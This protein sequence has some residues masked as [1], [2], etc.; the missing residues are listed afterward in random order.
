MNC[1]GGEL[2]SLYFSP[3][4]CVIIE[5]EYLW[6]REFQTPNT[7]LVGSLEIL[8][9]L[10]QFYHGPLSMGDINSCPHGAMKRSGQLE[11]VNL[12]RSGSQP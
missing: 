5:L 6:A 10:S 2:G 8:C 11:S 9:Y 12:Y 7:M 3:P 1:K 4:L